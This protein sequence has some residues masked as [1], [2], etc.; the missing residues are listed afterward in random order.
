MVSPV[1]AAAKAI[2]WR[3][4]YRMG[5]MVS[6]YVRQPLQTQ[7]CSRSTT[8]QAS[9]ITRSCLSLPHPLAIPCRRS[10]LR[11]ASNATSALLKRIPSAMRISKHLIHPLPCSPLQGAI[12][13]LSKRSSRRQKTRPL[14]LLSYSIFGPKTS[15]TSRSV[16]S[17]TC[18]TT[19]AYQLAP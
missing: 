15:A 12:T 16:T 5:S 10:V 7:P 17:S 14:P 13:I 6:P 2:W 4:Q 1:C 18:M 8:V 11:P 19:A 3:G 9:A